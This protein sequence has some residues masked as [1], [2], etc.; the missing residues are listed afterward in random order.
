M[1]LQQRMERL[2]NAVCEGM[3]EREEVIS[4]ALLGALCGQNTFLYGPPGTAKSLIS[5]RIA[6]AFSNPAYFEY[7]MNRFSTPEE[8]F[9]PISIKAL[10]EDQYVRKT[11]NYLPQADFAFLDEVWKS[12]P[13]ILNTLLTLINEHTFRNGEQIEQAPLKALVAASN[14]TPDANQGLEALYDRFIIRLMVGP[15][16]QSNNF[17]RLLACKPT[18]AAI[19]VDETLIVNANEWAEWREKL[20]GVR[21]SPETM[22]I[23]HLIRSELSTRYDELKV[24]VSDR[25]WQRAAQLMKAAAFF[26]GRSETNHSDALLLRHCLWTREENRIAVNEIVEQAVK[27]TGFDS[28]INL[29]QIDAEKESLEKEIHNEL[30]SAIDVYDTQIINGQAFFKVK[31]DFDNTRIGSYIFISLDNLKKTN[32]F[33]PTSESGN[34]L[35]YIV[36]QFDGQG[37]CRIS[38]KNRYES[39]NFKPEVLFHKGDKKN[40]INKRLITSLAESVAKTREQL[41]ATLDKIETQRQGYEKK[42]AS[43]FVPAKQ[44]ALAIDGIAEQIDRL[45]LRI[46]DC[47]RLE[48][49]CK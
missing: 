45:K 7:L 13:A 30:F 29:A 23:I 42:L 21:L 37:T 14:E 12:S 27:D 11:E 40:N 41:I 1:K 5:R 49:L 32:E 43:I 9:G 15:I 26:N 8:V 28:G 18:E 10:K 48:A 22:T 34:E 31:N 33:H 17:E 2:V 4:V 19:R 6:C 38:M 3:F 25:R 44:R 47:E 39:F 35:N 24:Y 16:E 46:K 20:H 36:C